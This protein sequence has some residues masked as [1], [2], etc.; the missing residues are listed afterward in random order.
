[1]TSAALLDIYEDYRSSKHFKK[2]R[3]T[4]ARLVEGNG[5]QSARVMIIGD[6]PGATETES[7][8]PFSGRSGAILDMLLATAGLT[9]RDCFLTTVVKY[10]TP[11]NRPP[12]TSEVLRSIKFLRREWM[13]I[14]PLVTIAAGNVAAAAIEAEEQLHG[15]LYPYWYDEVQGVYHKVS[16][17]YHPAFGLKS[18]QARK[19]IE[20]EWGLL[21]QELDEHCPAALCS[22][23]KG[24][25]PRGKIQCECT[26]NVHIS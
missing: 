25:G 26:L 2:L 22:D 17:V 20:K 9:R 5:S 13:E 21:G 12:S 1:M 4:G 10:R 15:V 16:N 23:C 14:R 8:I 3:D 18:K 24:L 19:W 7:G 6:T 11:G